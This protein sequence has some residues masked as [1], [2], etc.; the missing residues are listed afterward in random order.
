MNA[1]IITKTQKGARMIPMP[2]GAQKRGAAN[3]V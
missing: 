1:G 3:Q 2:L